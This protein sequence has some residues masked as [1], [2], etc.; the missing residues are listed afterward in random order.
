MNWAERMQTSQWGRITGSA[1]MRP[2]FDWLSRSTL[3]PYRSMGGCR[4]MWFNGP[5]DYETELSH[6]LATWMGE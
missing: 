6:E 1:L 3:D 4:N 2:W 5:E